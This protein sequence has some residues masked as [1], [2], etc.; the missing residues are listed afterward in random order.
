MSSSE[1]DALFQGDEVFFLR[2]L[3]SI[4]FKMYLKIDIKVK[5]F[6]I[7]EFT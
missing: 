4:K 5:V 2:L 3:F 6:F 7:F 1:E